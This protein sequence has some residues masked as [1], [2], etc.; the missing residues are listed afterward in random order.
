MWREPAV[1]PCGG[2]IVLRLALNKM[3]ASV[4][5]QIKYLSSIR[6]ITKLR[7]ETVSFPSGATLQHVTDW[8]KTKYDLSVPNR[9]IMATLNGRGWTQFDRQIE[10]EVKDGD[11]ICL[12]PP[13]SGG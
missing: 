4:S 13:V 11:V 12:F 1:C 7:S 8:L 10:T 6:D 9:G 3:D 5:L 2:S